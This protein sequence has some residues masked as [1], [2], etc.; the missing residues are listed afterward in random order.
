MRSIALSFFFLSNTAALHGPAT[1]YADEAADIANM[2]EAVRQKTEGSTGQSR[3]V[4]AAT[5]KKSMN[6]AADMFPGLDDELMKKADTIE[7]QIR[8]EDAAAKKST[9]KKTVLTSEHQESAH[10]RAARFFAAHGMEEVGRLLGDS[11][12]TQEAEKVKQE[13]A[14]EKQ[15]S[16]EDIMQSS[17][18]S[19]SIA[20]RSLPGTADKGFDEMLD[21][22]E[23]ANKQR[24][25]AVDALRRRA[26]VIA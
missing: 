1:N 21:D 24:W 4:T 19:P 8:E 20:K 3:V 23:E 11:L 17:K 18:A 13:A 14:E 10:V 26:P 12:S 9:Q 6:G 22:D 16:Q 7:E 5:A 2:M 15:K 25:K